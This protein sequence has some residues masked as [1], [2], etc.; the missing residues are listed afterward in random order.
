[1]AFTMANLLGVGVLVVAL[2][3]SGLDHVR[4]AEICCRIGP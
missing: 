3:C 4:K 2:P 1:M